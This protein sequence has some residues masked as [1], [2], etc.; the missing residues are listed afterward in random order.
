MTMAAGPGRKRTPVT[1]G[2]PIVTISEEEITRHLNF[3][4]GQA[5]GGDSLHHLI[6]VGA[7]RSPLGIPGAYG[8]QAVYLYA[9]AADDS[10]ED[11][12]LFVGKVIATAAIEQ[13]SHQRDVLFAA[14]SQEI[15]AIEK[16]DAAAQKLIAAKRLQEAPGAYEATVVYGV[17]RDG[18]RWRSRKAVTGPNA[19]KEEEVEI[20]TGPVRGPEFYGLFSDRLMR[21]L[22]GMGM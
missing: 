11:V 3:L 4:L 18:R 21:R 20:I 5:H 14:L 9:I 12:E 19:G 16:P 2:S 22:V 8:K 15:W 13:H 6:V 1:V 17:A 10:V 7:E